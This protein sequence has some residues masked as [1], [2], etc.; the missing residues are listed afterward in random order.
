M[1]PFAEGANIDESTD[2]GIVSP[3]PLTLKEYNTAE[4]PRFESM[5]FFKELLF[6]TSLRTP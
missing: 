1:D 2:R 3:K 5:R 4:D 6:T